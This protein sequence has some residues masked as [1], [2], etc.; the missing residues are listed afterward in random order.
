MRTGLISFVV[1]AFIGLSLLE[2]AIQNSGGILSTPLTANISASTLTIPADT[3]GFPAA[4][5]ANPQLIY[6][7]NEAMLYTSMTATQFNLAANGRGAN[8]TTRANH[9]TVAVIYNEDAQMVNETAG[10]Y[11][12]QSNT[13][14]GPL[15]IGWNTLQ[16]LGHAIPNMLTWN[17]SF[18][19]GWAV[20][21]AIFLNA[22][23]AA[24]VIGIGILFIT[25]A[26]GALSKIF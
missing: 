5:G 1:F 4:S 25:V 3:S 9:T 18:F 8:G 13:N 14:V 2:G 20:Y 17:F 7:E 19:T 26:W 12:I 10:F 22:F 11:I 21:I 6:V 15:N 24:V 16:F 23:S